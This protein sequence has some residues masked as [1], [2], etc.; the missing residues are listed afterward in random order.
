MSF[1]SG[2]YGKKCHLISW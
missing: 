1:K 2:A